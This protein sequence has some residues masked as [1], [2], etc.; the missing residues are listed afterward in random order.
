MSHTNRTRQAFAAAAFLLVGGVLAP[1]LQAQ[2]PV[3]VRL[4]GEVFVNSEAERYLR[5]LQVAGLANLYP[6]S[7]RSFSPVELDRILPADTAHPWGR[8]YALSPDTLRGLRLDWVRPRVQTIYN[9][10]FPYGSNDGPI[11]AGRGATTAVDF[12]F[13]A[14]YGPLSLTLAPMLFRAQNAAF[15]MAP[16]GAG[17]RLQYADP[18]NPRLI[19]LPQRF[20]DRPYSRF[21]PGQSTLRLDLPVVTLGVSTANQ[22]WGP[23]HEHPIL[24][25]NNAPGFLHGFAGTSA[26]LDLWVARVHG[27]MVWGQLEQSDYSPVTG[28]WSRRFMSGVVGVVLPRGV[29]GLEIGLGRFYHISWRDG[30]PAAT[31]FFR[32]MDAFLKAFVGSVGNP[33]GGGIVDNQLA[34]AFFRW[35]FPKSGFELYGEYGRNDHSWDLRD[36]LLQPD[37]NSAYLLGLQRV[38]SIPGE[39]LLTVRGEVLDAQITHL[40]RVRHQVPFYRHGFVRQGHTQRGQVLGSAAGYGGSGA[41]IA[42]DLYHPE[43]RFGLSWA[44]TLRRERVPRVRPWVGM[45]EGAGWGLDVLHHLQAESVFFRGRFEVGLNAGLGLNLNRDFAGDAANFHGGISVRAAL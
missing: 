22:H 26:P 39:R 36:F 12:G 32:P 42:G 2:D 23:A 15:Q 18:D 19:D 16:T 28:L 27:R 8:R 25:G 31:D 1:P 6:W 41:V 38:W 3:P 44:R 29:E 43:G 4:Q 5:T 13:A 37:H 11:W 40:E 30:G 21:D 14:R 33:E 9:S 24:L 7:I 20:G 17:G 35:V 10:A 45:E 34:S